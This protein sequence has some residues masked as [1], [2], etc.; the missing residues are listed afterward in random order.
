MAFDFESAMLLGLLVVPAAAMLIVR[1]SL[2]DSPRAQLVL[3]AAVRF[4]VLALLVLALAET[5]LVRR[6]REPAVLVLADLSDS[7]PSDAPGQVRRY[8]G[9]LSANMPGQAQAGLIVFADEPH[10]VTALSHTPE[11]PEAVEPP[12][13]RG[14]TRID[15]AL[16]RA[17][18]TFPTGVVK[19]IVLLSDGN[20]TQGDALAT[21]KRCAAR[22][23]RVYTHPY[24]VDERAEVLL[25]DLAVPAEVKKGQSFTV[26]ATAQATAR[27]QAH[28]VLYRNGFKA[29]ERTIELEPGANTIS[30][31]ETN[32]G[33]GLTRYELRVNAEEDFY[34]DNN[35]SSGVVFV[36]G[37]PRVLLLEGDEREAR[38]LA[39]TLEAENI[40]VQVRESK[41]MPGRLDELAR[42]DAVIFSDVP[43]TDVS[44]PQMN[45]LES[46]VEDLGGGF[47]MVGGEESFGP[48]G[49]YRTPVESALP[50][51]VRSQKRKDTPSLALMLIIDKSGSM[52]GDKVELA[53]EA[54]IAAVELLS[55]RDYVGVIAFDGSPYWVVDLQRASSRL[56]ITQSIATVTAGG[57]T[58]I[59]PALEEG[60][61]ALR[62]VDAA[63]K[64]AVVL[65]DGHSQPGDFQGLIGMMAASQ[66]TVSSVAVGEGADA[67]LLQDMAR[68][69]NGRFYYTADPYDIPQIFTKETMTAAKS[70]LIEEPFL[71]QVFRA[72]Q[73]VAGVDWE[74]APFLFGYVVTT[75]KPTAGVI[76][77]TERGDPLLARW[78]YGLG[79]T[80]AFT[81]DAKSRWAADWLGWPGYSR[82]WAQV[83]RS[84]LRTSQSRGVETHITR[85]GETGRLE[86]NVID[87]G[88]HFVNGLGGSMQV[89][90]PNLDIAGYPLAQT[91]PG[92]YETDFPMETPGSYLLKVQ[93]TVPSEEGAEPEVF[94]AFTR[95]VALSYEPEYRHLALNSGFLER[96]AKVSGGAYEAGAERVFR[97]EPE[98]AVAARTK[99]WP[100]LLAAALGLFLFD[101]AL[102]RLDLAGWRV[103][104]LEPRRYG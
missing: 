74:T 49:Y 33:D 60:Y 2:V 82:F 36:S 69:G 65:T 22:G 42:F 24:A 28:F 78:R 34:A 44:V 32:A 41:G 81:S 48:G 38:Y 18:E 8:L 30:F 4:I 98:E 89:V 72:G 71:A 68:W 19:R 15:R 21:A 58:S 86:V 51:R 11:W 46:Y 62:H 5:L 47:I 26:S 102:R 53:K 12:S 101:V 50:V 96:L 20:E 14:A 73:T 100:W 63:L 87:D 13:E 84:V 79:Q 37:E 66:I 77:V 52:Q 92:R 64:H 76:L 67:N 23:V 6:S 88:G 80:V 31:E 35:V 10:T 94:S 83:V 85:Q 3:S 39:R 70:S 61:D 55:E 95:G 93:Q 97:V 29:D 40:R 7:A 90:L 103:F 1:Y 54:A 75:P 99:L 56:A 57:G 27:M 104:R 45:L 91:G 43:A 16:F 17:L 59:Y 9:E 25:E